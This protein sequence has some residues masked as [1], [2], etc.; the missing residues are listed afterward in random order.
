MLMTVARR[1]G[2]YVRISDAREDDTA[3]V[4][5]QEADC[6][7]LAERRGWTVTEV[8]PENDT[9]AFKRRRVELPDGTTALRVVRPAFRK[10]LD[11]LAAGAIDA[12]V[13]YD[14]DRI[15]RDPRDLEDLIDVVEQHKIP[16]AA[17]TGSLDL[18]TD[19]GITMARIMVA[20]AN[21]SSRDTARRV[22]RKQLEMAEQG[23]PGGGGI[24][25]FG[26]D[27]TGM[28]VVEAEAEI[29]RELARRIVD[30]EA[31]LTELARDLTSRSV[32]TV[33]GAPIWSSRSVHSVVT[34]ARNAGLRSHK[35][36]IVGKAAWPA[37]LDEQTWRDVLLVL[38]G[39]AA[40]HTTKL[41][42]W[43]N[44]VLL[45]SLCDRPLVGGR[46][47]HKGHRYWCNTVKGGCGKI[48]I[49]AQDTERVVTEMILGYLKRP[50]VLADLHRQTSRKAT[51]QARADAAAAQ[52]QL[53][54][55]AEMW[56]KRQVTT[57]EYMA[58]RRPIEDEL[59]TTK[60]I[61]SAGVPAGV[62]K[63][64][65]ATDLPAG[66]EELTP[67]ECRDT[68]RVV[69]PNGIVVRPGKRGEFRYQA[70]RLAPVDWA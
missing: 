26:Y 42:R 36:E 58:A 4:D 5:R 20:V 21:K 68:A 61:L 35:G 31:T 16:T 69:F 13:A 6:R 7:A 32:P 39:R 25:T 1:A 63:L 24:R 37:I 28:L 56:G 70:E 40:G 67:A 11:D 51:A 41:Q 17:V 49:N 33:Q 29:V 43:L 9:S 55:L 48:V 46:A 12:L 30:E 47:P 22:A 54:E 38:A 64:L 14:L 59:R 23:I 52:A 19:A 60:A 34:K 15:A 45:C 10:L 3:G 57:A 2:G 62:R 8:Y 44:S 27:R 53:N 18:S 50:D 66:W 65:A